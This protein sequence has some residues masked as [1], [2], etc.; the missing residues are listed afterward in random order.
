[1]LER[2]PLLPPDLDLCLIDRAPE[3]PG[4]YVLR[5]VDGD[6]LHVGTAASLRRDIKAY[7]RLDRYCAKAMRVSRRVQGLEW[8]VC[9]G[10]L[11][12][13]LRKAMLS[14]SRRAAAGPWSLRVDPGSALSC[15]DVVDTS[16]ASGAE[17]SGDFYGLFETER[18]ARNAL[19]AL[20]RKHRLSATLLGLPDAGGGLPCEEPVE[21]VRQL[22]RLVQVLGPLRLKRWPYAGPVAVREHRD[23]H[24]FDR[25]RYLGTARDEG[26]LLPLFDAP[27][28][29]DPKV[30]R[31]LC[32]LIERR[33]A[34]LKRIGM[35][36]RE[37]R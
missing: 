14:N 4:V 32:G 1:V 33:P 15:V 22:S 26:E 2:E 36:A 27:V 37:H 34:K 35:P 28:R 8:H 6:V 7:F 21:R 10:P 23:L 11:G 19:V 25:W 29:F 20:A 13:R 9:E 5:D 18:K 3:A 12:A 17:A 31:L 24:L 30:Y 16:E